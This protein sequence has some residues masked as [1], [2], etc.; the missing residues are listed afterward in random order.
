MPHFI[1]NGRQQKQN[2]GTHIFSRQTH[3][4]R[5]HNIC[6]RTHRVGTHNILRK[7]HRFE[8]GRS[9]DKDEHTQFWNL[10]SITY[11]FSNSIPNWINFVRS[12]WFNVWFKKW[13]MTALRPTD[14]LNFTFYAAFSHS[15]PNWKT[16]VKEVFWLDF[17][18]WQNDCYVTKWQ[19]NFYL[20][21]NKKFSNNFSKRSILV[22]CLIQK[23]TK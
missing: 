22:Q 20:S 4:V 15:K 21:F 10:Q 8:R 11:R 19:L 2:V 5:T 7:T 14:S 1:M 17:I 12:F 3:K 13:R 16:F 6:R 9:S 18:N 23:V